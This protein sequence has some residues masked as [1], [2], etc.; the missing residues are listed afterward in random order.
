MSPRRS[1]A[2]LAFTCSACVA[3]AATTCTGANVSIPFGP[4]DVLN[5]APTDTQSDFLVTCTRDGGP[6]NILLTVSIGPSGASGAIATRQMRRAGGTELLGYNLFRDPSRFSV[7][8]QIAGVDTVSRSLSVPNNAS[9]TAIFTIFARV[10]AEQDLRIGSYTD[11][12][13][14]TVSY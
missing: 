2:L 11:S 8:G 5:P 10:P 1:L 7:W 3:H 4:Y 6:Q 12:L 13:I 14:I 9:A